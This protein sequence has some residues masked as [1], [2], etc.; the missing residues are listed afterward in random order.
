[1][2]FIFFQLAPDVSLKK[3]AAATPSF[4]GAELAALTNE[5]AIRTIPTLV[6]SF[7]L[8]SARVRRFPEEDRRSDAEFL[9]RRTR[10]TH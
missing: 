1:M 6:S 2:F 10:R 7:L 8:S 5:A 3:I 4:S 9:R